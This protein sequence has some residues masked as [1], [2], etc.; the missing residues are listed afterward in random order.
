[1]EGYGVKK[2]RKGS[3]KNGKIYLG[4]VRD[5]REVARNSEKWL[6]RGRGSSE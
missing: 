4:T 1:M 3:L 2:V 6:G 5:E